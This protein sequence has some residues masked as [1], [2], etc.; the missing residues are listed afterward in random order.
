MV[1]NK[2]YQVS[3]YD[4]SFIN[5]DSNTRKVSWLTNQN[6][7]H[8]T[9]FYIYIVGTINTTTHFCQDAA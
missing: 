1:V 7:N 3:S 8:V 9:S 4:T 2:L 5:F 6:A